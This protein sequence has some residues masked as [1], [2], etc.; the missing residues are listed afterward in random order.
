MGIET[1][2]MAMSSMPSMSDDLLIGY[3]NYIYWR[4]RMHGTAERCEEFKRATQ[5]PPTLKGDSSEL[6]HMSVADQNTDVQAMI[7]YCTEVD[8]LF[9][10]DWPEYMSQSSGYCTME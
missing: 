10:T 8:K 5:A 7:P 2:P 4:K 1:I 3:H 9:T 6:H